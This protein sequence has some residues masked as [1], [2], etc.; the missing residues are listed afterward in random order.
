MGLRAG[1]TYHRDNRQPG[2]R[3]RRPLGSASPP[4]ATPPHLSGHAVAGARHAPP[5]APAAG[6]AKET[7]GVPPASCLS[8]ISAQHRPSTCTVDL[9]MDLLVILGNL[10]R[11][12]DGASAARERAPAMRSWLQA[13][14]GQAAEQPAP[15][16]RAVR[17]G[18]SSSGQ[19]RMR[20]YCMSECPGLRAKLL[21]SRHGPALESGSLL[22][23]NRPRLPRHRSLRLRLRLHLRLLCESFKPWRKATWASSSNLQVLC[24]RKPNCIISHIQWASHQSTTQ[25]IPA[26][27]MRGRRTDSSAAVRV[28]LIIPSRADASM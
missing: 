1:S 3:V 28:V 8:A 2:P 7:T 13:L 17:G 12:A 24:F 25:T 26:N 11:I 22:V 23:T 21:V 16:G 27:S 15:P 10:G 9:R 20:R 19:V 5:K 6:F 18:R 14:P 4:G